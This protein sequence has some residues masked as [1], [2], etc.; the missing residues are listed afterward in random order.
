MPFSFSCPSSSSSPSQI[1]SSRPT[2]HL[3]PQNSSTPWL[4]ATS[5][6]ATQ[7]QPNPTEPTPLHST[8]EVT[9][10][11]NPRAKL[12]PRPPRNRNR[13]CRPQ[14]N[15]KN[16]SQ[17]VRHRWGTDEPSVDAMSELKL[18]LLP[19]DSR[20]LLCDRLHHRP[21]RKTPTK[22]R[23]LSPLAA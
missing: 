11:A 18:S 16:G 21:G 13:R 8:S 5:D 12:H 6:T 1:R 9:K 23:M 2:P 3:L 15:N 19:A 10:T 22:K 4:K 14:T 7:S 17:Q 20:A